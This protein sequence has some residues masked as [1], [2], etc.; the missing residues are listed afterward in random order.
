MKNFFPMGHVDRPDD[1]S[2]KELMVGGGLLDD[3]GKV[4]TPIYNQWL[5]RGVFA[6]TCEADGPGTTSSFSFPDIMTV[7]VIG[8]LRDFDIRLKKASRLAYEIMTILESWFKEN[9]RVEDDA[10]PCIYLKSG[11]K[12]EISTEELL[13]EAVLKINMFNIYCNV[14]GRLDEIGM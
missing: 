4:N 1:Y 2:P 6:A 12:I 8:A 14:T 13:G 3:R 11:N 10:W 9:P 5:Y 7:A